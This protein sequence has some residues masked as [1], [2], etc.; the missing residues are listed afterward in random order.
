MEN[1]YPEDNQLSELRKILVSVNSVSEVLPAS[2]E[3]SLKSNSQLEKSFQPLVEK[4]ITQSFEQNKSKMIEALFPII[5]ATIKRSVTE[6]FRSWAQSLEQVVQRSFTIEGLKWRWESK[7]TGLP[8]SQIAL[9]HA[10]IFKVEHV[11][12][13]H[14]D[15]NKTLCHVHRADSIDTDSS[16]FS[17]MVDVITDFV[18]DVF[19]A[20]QKPQLESLQFDQY[21]IWF[22]EVDSL[23][24]ASIIWGTPSL[25]LKMQ[26]QDTLNR[27]VYNQTLTLNKIKPEEQNFA[28]V[29]PVLETLLIESR[30][31][32]TSHGSAKLVLA[33]ISGVLLFL[34]GLFVFRQLQN[35]YMSTKYDKLLHQIRTSEDIFLV[36]FQKEDRLSMS[37]IASP[38]MNVRGV[39][40]QM[41]Q[42][43]NL[44][45]SDLKVR[46]LDTS[47]YNSEQNIKQIKF[48]EHLL[49]SLQR[50]PITVNLRLDSARLNQILVDLRK[51]Y[52]LSRMIDQT[53][54]VVLEYP[55]P[56][57]KQRTDSLAGYMSFMLERE[58]IYDYH[59]IRTRHNPHVKELTLVI[60]QE[61]PKRL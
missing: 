20:H 44:K 22:T 60:E 24:L 43:L 53:F 46:V 40:D 17:G 34:V 13:I 55:L 48:L 39:I 56:Q 54:V 32:A 27:I 28:E 33:G 29:E 51:D 52:F 10:L 30:K 38:V 9:R 19:I 45:S 14:K 11:F 50:Q 2:L 25:D 42:R 16:L 36:D 61:K 23:L 47:R 1:L 8:V 31:P 26:L 18:S 7:R 4:A 58:G 15:S 59:L 5:G 6:T 49:Q 37:V 41:A 12:L 35:Q 57:L 3:K 21:F